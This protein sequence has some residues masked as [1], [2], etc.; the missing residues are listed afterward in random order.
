MEQIKDNQDLQIY[1]HKFELFFRLDKYVLVEEQ[2]KLLSQVSASRHLA[3]ELYDTLVYADRSPIFVEYEGKKQE[4]TLS[5]YTKIMEQTQPQTE[6]EF[7]YQH[8]LAKVYEGI[9]RTSI[10]E[11]TIRG[12]QSTLAM[13]LI[14]D[15]IPSKIYENLIAAGQANSNLL[16]EFVQIK[17]NYLGLTKFYGTDNSLKIVG[18]YQQQFTVNQ[19]IVLIK[20]VLTVL[21]P[22]YQ[23][24]LNLALQPGQ[25]DYYEDTNKRQGA[26]SSGGEGVEPIILLNWDETLNSVNTLIHE[27]GHSVHTLLAEE[28]QPYPNAHY[29]IILAEVASTLNEHLLFDYL[30]RHSKSKDEK[31][32][33]LQ[34]RIEEVIGTFFRQIQFA[35]F[36]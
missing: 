35:K 32:Y 16:R 33:L 3:T 19:A 22:K 13:G 28:S 27:L 30:Y 23:E 25:I 6:Q 14:A 36:E 18:H 17:K 10:E 11:L 2:E 31:I 20:E 5:L 21:G 29:P 8:S 15:N 4:L 26:Y 1:Q 24:K 34:N 7:R 12:Y 9:L